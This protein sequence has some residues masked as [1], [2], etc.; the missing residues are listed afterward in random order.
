MKT[1]IFST[2]LLITAFM[3]VNCNDDDNDPP[4]FRTFFD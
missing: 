4:D 2:A 1:K 3:F